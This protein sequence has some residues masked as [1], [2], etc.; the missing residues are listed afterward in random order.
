MT[1]ERDQDPLDRYRALRCSQVSDCLDQVGLRD[2]AMA[3]RLRPLYP[4]ARLTGYAMT[5]RLEVV[6]EVP[7]D[8]SLWYQGEL[9]AIDG[10][11]P[12]EVMVVSTCPGPIWGEL[13]ATASRARGAVG[14][15]ADA[16]VRDVVQ[17]TE[18]QFPTFTSLIHPTDGLG[19]ADVTARQVPVECGD[20]TVSP[21]DIVVA[22]A[23]GIVVVPEAAAGEV[24]RLAEKKAATEDIVRE[25]LAR[26]DS[27]R[28]VF[29]RH[30]V[31]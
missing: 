13:L 3:A 29:R 23:D 8:Q 22:D 9:E 26:G 30:G 24:L 2:N 19:R 21:G 14:I 31:L 15:V 11:K 18:M 12:G 4:G 10:L 7:D 20:V 5:I 28:E 16:G 27:V 25:E 1:G 6:H 17:L